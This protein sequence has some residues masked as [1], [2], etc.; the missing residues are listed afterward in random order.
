M[1][2]GDI[3][4]YAISKLT[5]PFVVLTITLAIL[6]S[7]SAL[8][9]SYKRGYEGQRVTIIRINDEMEKINAETRQNNEAYI[10]WQKLL[11][12]QTSS[13]EN[14]GLQ[15]DPVRKIIEDLRIIHKIE[16]LDTKLSTPRT[17]PDY[18]NKFVQLEEAEVTMTFTNF[19]DAN[20]FAFINE[21]LLKLPGIWQVTSL[22]L[23]SPETIDENLLNAIRNGTNTDVIRAKVEFLWRDFKDIKTEENQQE[24]GG[25]NN[26][27]NPR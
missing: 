24:R 11:D 13:D 21:L 7:I 1:I 6:G 15:T 5:P 26:A 14:K 9:Y 20:I 2:I 4:G 23:S 27:R 25:R 19:S 8:H 22:E 16:K 18:D 10:I 17:N 12:K 3:K